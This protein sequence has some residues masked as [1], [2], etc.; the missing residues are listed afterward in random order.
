MLAGVLGSTHAI[1]VLCHRC[2]VKATGAESSS[3]NP[4]QSGP[5]IKIISCHIY[6]ELR[7]GSLLHACIRH[8]T[9][10]ATVCDGTASREGVSG[11]EGTRAQRDEVTVPRTHSR[12]RI[13]VQVQ[14]ILEP[15]SSAA[16]LHCHVRIPGSQR[17]HL[18]LGTVKSL[19]WPPGKAIHCPVP[20]DLGFT[21]HM[22]R[23]TVCV[24][25]SR[26]QTRNSWPAL[27]WALHF[28]SV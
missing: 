13:G 9:C 5:E 3:F 25:G 6:R 21:C 19:A 12:V 11:H 18:R 26:S 17:W 10:S 20:Q 24:Q 15:G 16:T 4:S 28:S 7:P 1:G 22:F 23:G 14:L 8:P 27:L 2:A